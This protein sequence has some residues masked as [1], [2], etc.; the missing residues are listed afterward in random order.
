MTKHLPPPLQLGRSWPTSVGELWRGFHKSASVMPLMGMPE[1]FC[2]ARE[3]LCTTQSSQ[4]CLFYA[5]RSVTLQRLFLDVCARLE[6]GPCSAHEDQTSHFESFQ[7]WASKA[8]ARLAGTR[9]QDCGG[10]GMASL[11]ADLSGD[12]QHVLL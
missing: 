11:Q 9:R 1:A 10:A 3:Q 2:T 4:M 12:L 5:L 7:P 6:G 8:A